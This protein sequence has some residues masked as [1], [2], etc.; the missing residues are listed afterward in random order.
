M[1]YFEEEKTK[2]ERKINM[3]S[4]VCVFYKKGCRNGRVQEGVVFFFFLLLV[5]TQK[6][7]Q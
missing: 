1:L 6:T 2:N 5:I 3:Y 4:L 7:T